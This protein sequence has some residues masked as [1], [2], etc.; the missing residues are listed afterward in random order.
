M[1]ST[2]RFIKSS[3]I[4]LIA[5]TLSNIIKV[6]ANQDY[7]VVVIGAWAISYFAILLILLIYFSNLEAA[8]GL[9]LGSKLIS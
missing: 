9:F 2:R 1:K 6:N 5:I 3:L 4:G 7:D 8:K